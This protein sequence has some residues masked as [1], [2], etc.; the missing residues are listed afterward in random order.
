MWGRHLRT[1]ASSTLTPSAGTVRV[2]PFSSLRAEA[3]GLCRGGPLSIAL[4]TFSSPGS[5]SRRGPNWLLSPTL[6]L[7]EDA[8]LTSEAEW[9]SLQESSR[10]R[11]GGRD[12]SSQRQLRSGKTHSPSSVPERGPLGKDQHGF[13]PS[14]AAR[15]SCERRKGTQSGCFL[16]VATKSHS[17]GPAGPLGT[18]PNHWTRS[19]RS[20]SGLVTSLTSAPAL[21]PSS[22]GR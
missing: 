3:P 16:S 8:L 12:N 20:P 15:E 2:L 13:C 19:S 9:P 14:G 5:P 11:E 7:S 17:L 1:S 22:Q 21:N 6:P 10:P 18:R 4:P